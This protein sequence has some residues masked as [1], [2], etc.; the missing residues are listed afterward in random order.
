MIWVIDSWLIALLNWVTM[1]TNKKRKSDANGASTSGGP[2]SST[3]FRKRVR[4]GIKFTKSTHWD[5]YEVLRQRNIEP[6]QYFCEATT[7]TLGLKRDLLFMFGNV[8][9]TQFAQTRESTYRRLTLEFLSSVSVKATRE[10]PERDSGT[11]TFRLGNENHSITLTRLNSIFGFPDAGTR[12]PPESYNRDSFWYAITDEWLYE[13]KKAKASSIRNPCLRYAHKVMAHTIFGRGDTGGVRSDELALLWCMVRQHR[14]NMNSGLLLAK[15]LEHV[16]K[17][18]SGAIVVGGLISAIARHFGVSFG[19]DEILGNERI[20]MGYL[21]NVGIIHIVNGLHFYSVGDRETKLPN[22]T[23]TTVRNDVGLAFTLRVDVNAEEDDKEEEEDHETGGD[24]TIPTLQPG[25]HQFVPPPQGYGPYGGE[26][27]V[28]GAICGLR[29]DIQLMREEQLRYQAGLDQ[30][31]DA[32]FSQFGQS[33]H[34]G[35]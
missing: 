16:A 24:N 27:D 15:Q 33:G 32:F 20:D 29:E 25:V 8:G 5:R 10:T 6:T 14:M 11:I 23:L 22:P 34:S 2:S 9:W 12:N 31:L 13:P 7:K 30:R 28:W 35:Q 19:D 17:A 1:S 3:R 21:R 26:H 4:D 18:S